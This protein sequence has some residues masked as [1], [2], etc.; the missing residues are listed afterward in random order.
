MA[1]LRVDDVTRHFGGLTALENVSFDCDEGK[2]VGIVGPN[3]AGKTTL[4]NLISGTHS[5]SSGKIFYREKDITGL[6]PHSLCARGIGKINQQPRVFA[7]QSV[8]D[9]MMVGAIFGR[10]Q[11]SGKTAEE[12]ALEL[13][14]RFDLLNKKDE[15]AKNLNRVE[16]KKMEIARALAAK[17]QLLLLDEP[18]AGHTPT[19]ANDLVELIRR[20]NRSGVTILLIEHIFK[21]VLSLSDKI[22][23]LDHGQVIAEGTPNEIAHNKLVI[24]AYVGEKTA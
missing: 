7:S 23:V 9:N 6:P 24:D 18:I 4:L 22:L 12:E 3:G 16:M 20:I 11:T 8:L 19:E 10:G 14:G 2:I 13:L 1:L 5:P 15:E 21:A 17:P